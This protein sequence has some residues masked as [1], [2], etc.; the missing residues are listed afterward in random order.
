M[1]ILYH[2]VDDMEEN[3]AFLGSCP[4]RKKSVFYSNVVGKPKRRRRVTSAFSFSSAVSAALI[5]LLY[6]FYIC[7]KNTKADTW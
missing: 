6:P 3:N 2:N 4:L 5:G 1:L 7:V